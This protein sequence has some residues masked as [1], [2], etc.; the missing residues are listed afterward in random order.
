MPTASAGSTDGSTSVR[1]NRGDNSVGM[2]MTAPG[3]DSDLIRRMRLGDESALEALYAR[4]GGLLYTLALRVVGDPELA[5]EVLQ[6]TVLRAWD[7]RET[8]DAARGRVP[9]W[10][11]GIARN[12]A[13]DLLRSRSHQAR[14]RESARLDADRPASPGSAESVALR[15]VVGHALA[16]LSA[17]QRAAIELAYYDGLTQVEIAAKL[18]EPL[19]TIKSR[20]REAMER[21]RGLLGPLFAIEREVEDRR[22]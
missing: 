12:R 5:R 21:L 20:T 3:D 10:L 14:L 13:I 1:S 2:E 16:G 4:Y 15:Q 19:G 7:G 18:Q 9:W 8:Y 6:D 17:V 11:M 22:E